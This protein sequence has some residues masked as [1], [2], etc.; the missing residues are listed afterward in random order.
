MHTQKVLVKMNKMQRP[1]KKYPSRDTVPLKEK[2]QDK[3]HIITVK[4]NCENL[5]LP[6]E[7]HDYAEG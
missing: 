6:V 5:P 4:E 7:V 3:A 2:R 1:S